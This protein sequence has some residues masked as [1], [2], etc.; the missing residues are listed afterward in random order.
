VTI[1]EAFGRFLLVKTLARG[2]MGEVHL[3]RQ[4]GMEGFE[5]L[6]VVKRILPH[7]AEDDEFVQMFLDEAR[8]AANLNH[9][10]IVQIYDLGRE[11]AYYFIAMEYIH[12]DDIRRLWKQVLKAKETLPPALACRIIADAAAG[13]DYA[14]KKC[15]SAGDPLGIVHRDISPHNILVTFEGGVKVI[16][17]GIARAR[18]RMTH[19]ETGAIKG[20]FEYMSPEHAAGQQLDGR[21]DVFALGVVLWETLTFSRLFKRDSEAATL[22]AVNDCVVPPPSSVVPALPP[23]LDAV[24]LKALAKNREDRYRDAG[25]FRLALEEWMADSRQPSSSAHLGA[26]MRLMYAERL[27]QERNSGR[28]YLEETTAS[29]GT[30]SLLRAEATQNV[31]QTPAPA[32]QPTRVVPPK[33]PAK[34]TGL[35]VG[36][37]ALVAAL[38][39][40]VYWRVAEAPRPVRTPVRPV[41]AQP[42]L[43]DDVP[44]VPTPTAATTTLQFDSTP[45]AI[46][47]ID[48][49]RVGDTP[50]TLTV[51]WSSRIVTV[52]FVAN[53]YETYETR[54]DLKQPVRRAPSLKPRLPQAPAPMA[55]H[56]PP[57]TPLDI[58]SIR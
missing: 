47:L 23:D 27:E 33:A 45:P 43:R 28:P 15:D 38:M 1:P 42:S 2:G 39:G 53:G 30:A 16:D 8:I 12:G 13:L 17:F 19:T 52:A 48:G 56:R 50:L 55:P 54:L 40:I 9:P 20:R 35:V 29:N 36:A 11:G 14:H 4:A 46:V 49:V 41:S 5:K 34:Q 24:V 21:S 31:P 10:N 44:T 51:G 22:V 6:V 32:A 57:K 26:Y 7:L 18:N 37:L 58:K 3:A 25:E